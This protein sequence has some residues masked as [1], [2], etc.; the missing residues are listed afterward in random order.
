MLSR[1]VSR[2]VSTGP[3]PTCTGSR[4]GDVLAAVS[5]RIRV[6][7]PVPPTSASSS[8]MTPLCT[9]RPPPCRIRHPVAMQVPHPH[10]RLSS[11]R[12]SPRRRSVTCTAHVQARPPSARRLRLPRP[13]LDPGRGIRPRPG[14]APPLVPARPRPWSRPGP[15]IGPEPPGSGPTRRA[16]GCVPVVRVVRVVSVVRVVRVVQAFRVGRRDDSDDA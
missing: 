14:R 10:T 15:A 13:R 2:K 12:A 1:D 7:W 8:A 9:I 5:S 16:T 3:M 6:P 11:G 4:T